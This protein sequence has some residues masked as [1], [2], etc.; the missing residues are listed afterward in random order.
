[1]L[2]ATISQIHEELPFITELLLQTDSAKSYSNNFLLCVIS[3]LN[4]VHKHNSLATIEFIHKETQDGKTILDAFFARCMKFV[5]S[6]ISIHTTNKIK[7]IGTALELGEALAYQGGMNN[8]MVQVLTTN[9]Q[10]TSS[11]EKQFE[12]VIKG[13]SKYFQELITLILQLMQ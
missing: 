13:F 4:V 3:L 7:K 11:I 5:K 10:V 9:K 8:A 12:D 2:D 1:M 6:Y